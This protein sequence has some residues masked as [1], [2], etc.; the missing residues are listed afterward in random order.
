MSAR[1]AADV[2]H[3]RL[4]VELPN[5]V[6]IGA[7]SRAGGV[8]LVPLFSNGDGS[9]YELFSHARQAGTA[10]VKEVG[11]EGAVPH[12]EVRNQ[13][14]IPVLLLDG[15]ILV[16]LKQN[17]ILNTTILVAPK[18]TLDVPVS[19]VEAGRWRRASEKA[20]L[21]RYA[22]SPTI[23]GQKMESL[24]LSARTFGKFVADQFVVWK[25]VDDSL[26]R[27]RVASRTRAYSEI[28][29]RKSSAIDKALRDVKPLPGQSGVAAFIDNTPVALDLFD[30]ADTLAIAWDELIGSYIS[31]ALA[32]DTTRGDTTK[33]TDVE[34]AM[35]WIRG[36][37]EGETTSHPGVGLG[38]TVLITSDRHNLS[39]LVADGAP[40][41]IAAWPADAPGA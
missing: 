22:V 8:T 12:V 39:A 25:G 13:G 26:R 24:S 27:H 38:E 20:D 31:D 32:A 10:E 33:G 4:S 23:R 16:G 2:V 15:E 5:G 37:T 6:R 7:P 19:C 34:A 1:T 21:G 40:V 41:H 3:D 28:E 29:A 35:T 9:A 36:L 17:R 18:S 30:K 14:R 11:V